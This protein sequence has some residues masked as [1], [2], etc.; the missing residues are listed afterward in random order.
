MA[1][2]SDGFFHYSTHWGH[3]MCII[4]VDDDPS[5]PYGAI[6]NSWGD[7]FGVIKDFKTGDVWPKGTLRVR[8]KDIL[9]IL[10]EQD[11]FAYS[12]LD[13]FPAQQLPDEAFNLW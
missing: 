13:G 7:V 5:D 3:Q 6:L 4:G 1:A 2:R 8:K 11:S 9:S 10:S 12:A